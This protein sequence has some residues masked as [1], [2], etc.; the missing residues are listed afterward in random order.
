MWPH[1]E[2]VTLVDLIYFVFTV[3]PCHSSHGQFRSPLFRVLLP[4]FT[5]SVHN[6]PPRK[7]CTSVQISLVPSPTGLSRG[8]WGTIQQRTSSS[9]YIIPSQSSQASSCTVVLMANFTVQQSHIN[10]P[11]GNGQWSSAQLCWWPISLCNIHTST[12]LLGTDNG[13]LHS[14][15]QAFCPECI[16]LADC[17]ML[18]I[19]N[20]MC[21]FLVVSAY[22]WQW[23]MTGRLICWTVNQ[24]VK[25]QV[26]DVTGLRMFLSSSETTLVPTHQCLSRHVSTACTMLIARYGSHVQ[27]LL[28]EGLKASGTETHM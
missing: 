8:T 7:Q 20:R 12:D 17:C 26:L 24:V 27:L 16:L 22:P 11:V 4:S 2:D 25:V 23:F 9:L 3:V 18:D 5:G 6:C 19:W 10:W 14:T 21:M 15:P 28:R 1:P 13:V